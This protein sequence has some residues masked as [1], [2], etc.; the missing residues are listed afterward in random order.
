MA[1]AVLFKQGKKLHVPAGN[2][3]TLCGKDIPKSA[4]IYDKVPLVPDF[5]SG[6]Y[7]MIGRHMIDEYIG[8]DNFE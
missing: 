3:Q 1:N 6:C 2:G 5:C 4:T 8:L 7:E